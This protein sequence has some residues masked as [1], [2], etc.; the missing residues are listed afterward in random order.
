MSANC[1]L[2][3]GSSRGSGASGRSEQRGEAVGFRCGSVGRWWHGRRE[4]G[5]VSI[6]LVC[7]V[8]HTLRKASTVYKRLD[9]CPLFPFAPRIISWI[10]LERLSSMKHPSMQGAFQRSN[11]NVLAKSTSKGFA[12]DHITDT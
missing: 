3:C 12:Y 5:L 6:E 8:A 10:G 1:A 9:C 7:A 2:L 4:G 11:F